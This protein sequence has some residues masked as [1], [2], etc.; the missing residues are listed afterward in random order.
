MLE[1]GRLELRDAADAARTAEP[2]PAIDDRNTGGIVTPVL[3]A[4]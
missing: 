3:E 4:F 2:V 1:Q